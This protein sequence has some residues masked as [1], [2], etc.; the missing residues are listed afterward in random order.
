MAIAIPVVLAG[1]YHVKR[2]WR[3]VSGG[4]RSN[5]ISTTPKRNASL[6]AGSV[7]SKQCHF[8]SQVKQSFA[9]QPS[10]TY[11]N[12]ATQ[13]DISPPTAQ[14]LPAQDS[15][16]ID[17]EEHEAF[18][19]EAEDIARSHHRLI[20]DGEDETDYTFGP[21]RVVQT[22][23]DALRAAH[24]FQEAEAG[25]DEE[26]M[27]SWN[28]HSRIQSK[29]SICDYRIAVAE[30]SNSGEV[31]TMRAEMDNL[32]VCAK[33]SI[34]DWRIWREACESTKRLTSGGKCV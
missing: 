10:R 30:E 8:A 3:G 29:F 5:S 2:L 25:A 12:V 7:E 19:A 9:T 14:G 16:D 6:A 27:R 24:K 21:I 1:S 18:D 4:S 13:T 11:V 34:V 28:L 26:R 33:W 22:F 31:E 17:F 20:F 23:D 32:T 15:S